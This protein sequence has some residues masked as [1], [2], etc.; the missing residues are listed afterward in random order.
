MASSLTPGISRTHRD[1]PTTW[2]A[3]AAMPTPAIQG[4]SLPL[5]MRPR[6]TPTGASSAALTTRKR[7][8]PVT[9]F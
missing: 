3:A 2:T 4:P 8:Q 7:N 1:R 5:A 9:A 6:R